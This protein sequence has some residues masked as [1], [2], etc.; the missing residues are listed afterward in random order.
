MILLGN[1]TLITLA[2]AGAA[3]ATSINWT[4]V[5]SVVISIITVS[6]TG[7]ATLVKI[8]GGKRNLPDEPE[9]FKVDQRTLDT[10][11]KVTKCVSDIE[12]LK[13][14]VAEN[15]SALNLLDHDHEGQGKMIDELKQDN[16][17][18]TS[19]LD[20]LLRQLIE[21]MNEA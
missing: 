20:E 18:L 9:F 21:W 19:K 4:V 15:T 6:L 16:K 7:M 5:V 1:I 8:F 17:I 2:A 11:T 14:S 10:Q 3:G 12:E 13:K